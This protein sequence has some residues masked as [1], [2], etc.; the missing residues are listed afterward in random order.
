MIIE[1]IRAAILGEG[2]AAATAGNAF[3]QWAA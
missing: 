2:E 1:E 3:V